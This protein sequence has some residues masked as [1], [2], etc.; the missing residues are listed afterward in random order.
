[1]CMAIHDTIIERSICISERSVV[2]LYTIFVSLRCFR[3]WVHLQN[4]STGPG[5]LVTTPMTP[6]PAS[7]GQFVQWWACYLLLGAA[8]YYFSSPLHDARA[9]RQKWSLYAVVTYALYAW[10][11]LSSLLHLP[12]KE[13]LLESDV[14]VPASLLFPVFWLTLFTLTG[15]D[16]ALAQVSFPR[17]TP[18]T[19]SSHR[20]R[21][22]RTVA[23]RS[24][25]VLPPY[26]LTS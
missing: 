5:P 22:S 18:R 1:M 21:A 2:T 23:L 7:S 26:T 19:C 20:H 14:H 25:P 17:S 10:L 8:F 24:P 11:G 15:F 13:H 16:I 6:T 12:L 3:P 9:R 4:R